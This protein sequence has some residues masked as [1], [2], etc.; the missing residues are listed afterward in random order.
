MKQFWKNLERRLLHFLVPKLGLFYLRF[1]GS[2][3]KVITVG[4]T[5]LEQLR[6][7][8]PRVIFICWHEQSLYIAWLLRKMGITVLVSQ[9]R[10]GEYIANIMHALGFQT[11]RGSSSRGGS[12]ALRQLLKT[13]K[14]H[15]DTGIVVDGP[16]GP[17]LECK[18]G[19]VTLA[20]LS[21]APIIPLAAYSTRY[22]RVKSWDRTYVPL[23]FSTMTVHYGEPIF[24]Q[25]NSGDDDL[26]DA[27]Q[28]VNQALNSLTVVAQ[29]M[30]ITSPNNANP[31][32]SRSES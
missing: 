2:T 16:R 12:Q 32:S 10:D 4:K 18:P 28:Q 23:P 6:T 20:Q 24:F 19:V 5:E 17:A 21:G 9:S 30:L 14:K 15:G 11:A 7:Q 1:V 27:Q 13:L 3:S 29:N 26:A 31:A 22:R 8:H 25:R